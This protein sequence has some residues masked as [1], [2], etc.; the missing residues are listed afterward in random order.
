[1]NSHRTKLGLPVI[2]FETLSTLE[3]LKPFNISYD[4]LLD[5]LSTLRIDGMEAESPEG[6]GTA[7]LEE[8]LLAQARGFNEREG[9]NA[10]VYEASHDYLKDM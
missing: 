1:M 6:K 3:D 2:D 10:L 9:V 7:Y 8:K 4:Q 5:S